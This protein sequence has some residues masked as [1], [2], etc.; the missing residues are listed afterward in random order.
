MKILSR[1]AKP[2]YLGRITRFSQIAAIVFTVFVSHGAAGVVTSITLLEAVEVD[3]PLIYL[4]QIA[5]FDG[6]DAQ[7]IQQLKDISVGKA[8]LPSRSRIVETDFIKLRLRQNGI[9]LAT[10]NLNGSRRVKITRSFIEIVG[11][12]MEKIISDYLYQEALRG[13]SS[14][15]VK[16]MRVPDRLILPKGSITYQV[17]PPKNSNFLGKISLSIQFHVDGKLLKKVW[18]TATV[19]LFVDVL[20]AKHPLG[21][22][23]PIG[24]DDLELRRM[25]LAQLPL[26][27]IFNSQD[28]VGKRT[29]QSIGP[30]TPLRT[31]MIELPPII[32]R[33]D[34]VVVV[35][36]SKGLRITAMGKARRRGRLGERIPVENLDSKK[37]L[38][39]RIIDSRTVRLEY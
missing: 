4:G 3:G 35:V 7:L 17:V 29:R 32:Q 10:L 28:V 30:G 18:V 1:K 36:E 33:G 19:E 31:D 21:K 16:N 39:A 6:Q 25:D 38:Y 2:C 23:K 34:V 37:I 14:A 13:E 8:P 27:V 5:R 12:E 22:H 24:E 15:K 20:V 26:N 11:A 9:N